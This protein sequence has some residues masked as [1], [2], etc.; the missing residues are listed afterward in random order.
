MVLDQNVVPAFRDPPHGSQT[1]AEQI[2]GTPGI[3][4]HCFLLMFGT[5][6][7]SEHANNGIVHGNRIFGAAGEKN[8]G[9]FLKPP[10]V[11]YGFGPKCC[12]GVPGIVLR[13]K[14][15]DADS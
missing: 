3:R 13:A 8:R 1:I 7:D 15:V 4:K 14:K 12:S 9:R 6:F 11:L 10:P 5:D 2:P